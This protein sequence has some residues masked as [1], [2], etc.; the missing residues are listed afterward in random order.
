MLEYT[1]EDLQAGQ[2]AVTMKAWDNFN[3]F[4]TADISFEVTEQN[5]LSLRYVL[6][7]PNPFNPSS[8]DTRFTYELSR[9]ARVT[10]KIYTVA[11]RLICTLQQGEIM[12]GY[13]ESRA[14]DGTDQDGDRV[15]NGVY[16]YKIIARAEGKHTEAYGKVVVMH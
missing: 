9:P 13:N 1:L 10:I 7:C 16:L 2:H 15:A 4:T 14:W 6:N 8:E 3:N 5:E 11:G 12:Q